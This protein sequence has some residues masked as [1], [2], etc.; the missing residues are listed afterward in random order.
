MNNK[1][2]I[3]HNA[4]GGTGKTTMAIFLAEYYSRKGYKTVVIDLD[5]QQANACEYFVSQSVLVEKE[6]VLLDIVK[7]IILNMEHLIK[8]DERYYED[9]KVLVEKSLLDMKDNSNL[10][11]IASKLTI[12]DMD[13]ILGNNILNMQYT[14]LI[15]KKVLYKMFDFIIVDTPPAITP[16]VQ[17]AYSG[18]DSLLIVSDPS[19]FGCIGISK[20]LSFYNMLKNTNFYLDNVGILINRYESNIYSSMILERLRASYGDKIFNSVINK[21]VEYQESILLKQFILSENYKVK[22][23]KCEIILRNF[24]NEMDQ[25]LGIEE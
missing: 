17:S 24:L 22:N 18:F 21:Y 19:E 4:K 25:R 11:C 1:S 20:T 9:I 16:T 6:V 2:I 8:E 12:D 15:L 7:F 23:K 5:Y 14:F 13:R 3:V 10:Y